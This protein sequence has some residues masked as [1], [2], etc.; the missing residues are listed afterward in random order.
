[1]KYYNKD[2][3]MLKLKQTSLKGNANIK[4]YDNATMT[5]KNMVFEDIMPTSF[6]YFSNHV[7]KLNEINDVLKK[8]GLDIFHLNGYI[9]F[10][11]DNQL[12]TLTPPIIE[13]VDGKNLLLDGMHRVMLSH[14]LGE[15]NIQCVVINGATPLPYAV[16]NT[17]GWDDVKVF[18]SEVPQ[19]FNTR[20]RRYPASEYKYYSRIFNFDGIVQVPRKHHENDKDF[21]ILAQNYLIKTR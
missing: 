2:T 15:Q 12:L 11:K 9:E 10:E 5:L 3:L 19:G 14:L 20:N 7:K 4:P 8:Q 21:K 13:V 18:E 1:M 16:E 17:N 6:Y